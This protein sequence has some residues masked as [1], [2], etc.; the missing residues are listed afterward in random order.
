M[1][2]RR[3]K[4][5]NLRDRV[6]ALRRERDAHLMDESDYVD[7]IE[8]LIHQEVRDFG[9]RI[10]DWPELPDRKL[11]AFIDRLLADYK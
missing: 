7:A 2:Y 8:A 3:P 6:S 10:K 5:T 9:E 4:M 11:I 1:N